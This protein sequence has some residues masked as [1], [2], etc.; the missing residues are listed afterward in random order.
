MR[1]QFDKRV[2]VLRGEEQRER[3]LALI[4]N[5]PV[6]AEK[7]LQIVVDEYKP[8]RKKSQNDLM[9]AGPLKDMED[10]AF[11]EGRKYSS[12]VWAEFFKEQ[13]LP[14]AFDS[15]LCRDGYVKW[16]EDPRGMRKMVGSTTM[17]TVKGFAQYLEQIY[18]F[19]SELGVQFSV[20]PNEGRS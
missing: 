1:A 20:N 16:E 15:E 13:F 9:W 17:L 10:Q 3:A 12:K 7:P 11:L 14:E 2:I 5:L 18:V 6:D 4:R 19:G 8:P